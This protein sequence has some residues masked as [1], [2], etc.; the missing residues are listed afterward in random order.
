MVTSFWLTLYFDEYSP[1]RKK[2]FQI[3]LADHRYGPK[4]INA[5]TDSVVLYA[6]FQKPTSSIWCS[7]QVGVMVERYEQKKNKPPIS[8][9][10]QIRRVR[11]EGKGGNFREKTHRKC[12]GVHIKFL[13]IYELVKWFQRFSTLLHIVYKIFYVVY[14]WKQNITFRWLPCDWD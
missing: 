11:P 1:Y 6:D 5:I 8:N 12:S 13:R 9:I 2:K 3:K 4:N 7:Y 14:Y 10:I